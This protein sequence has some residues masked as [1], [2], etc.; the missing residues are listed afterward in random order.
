MRKPGYS[1]RTPLLALIA[2]LVSALS[3]SLPARELSIEPNGDE[4]QTLRFNIS[5]NGYPPYLI[6]SDQ[7]P[8]GIMWEVMNLIA[9]RL[10]F[11]VDPVKI[12]RKRVD[13]MLADGY[14]DATPRTIEWTENPGDYLFT[15]PVVSVEEVFFFPK[16]SELSYEHPTDLYGKIIVAHLG[17]VYPVLEPYFSDRRIRRFDVSRDRDLFT[18]VLH[19]DQFH[20]ALADRLAGQWILKNEGLSDQFRTSSESISQFGFRFMLRKDC[21]EFADAFNKELVKIRENGELDAILSKY[22]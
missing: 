20:A 6:V 9:P 1:S 11:N 4:P 18:F 13:P 8:S 15:D 3:M 22:R 19:G 14:I 7:G 17:Y 10:G 12:P 2:V 16:A 21:S 5:P